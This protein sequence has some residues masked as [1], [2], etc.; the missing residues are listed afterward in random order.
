MASDGWKALATLAIV[1][2]YSRPTQPVTIAVVCVWVRQG[3]R[4]V[5]AWLSASDGRGQQR[6]RGL[7]EIV[8]SS[9]RE[10]LARIATVALEALHR[11]SDAVLVA[12]RPD[13][14]EPPPGV[15]AT[16]AF[17][18]VCERHRVRRELVALGVEHEALSAA[19]R[20]AEARAAGIR[21]GPRADLP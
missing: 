15:D 4:L 9:R 1:P 11:P 18:R 13:A 21:R 3:R 12:R 5:A 17:A 16:E 7:A 8:D 6:T 10:G 2:V 14:E 19:E 20:F